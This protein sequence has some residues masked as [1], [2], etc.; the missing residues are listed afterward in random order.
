[1]KKNYYS[2]LLLLGCYLTG[3]AQ[4]TTISSFNTLI[5]SNYNLGLVNPLW[6]QGCVMTYD[7]GLVNTNGAAFTL[8]FTNP[9]GTGF[10][11]YP[12]GTVGNFKANSTYYT[13]NTS[14]C[15]LPVKIQNLGNNL[16]LKWKVSQENANDAD[17]K[18]WATINV[19]FDLSSTASSEPNPDA[20]DF[21]LVIQLKSYEQDTFTNL[22][23]TETNNYT[24]WYFARNTD[25]SLKT[26]DLYLN[27]IMYQFA[28][29]YKFFNYPQ[30]N[31]DGT[32]NAN[33]DKNDKVH[34]KFIPLNNNV[35][36]PNL[37]HSLKY[38]IDKSKEYKSFLPLTASESVLFDQKVAD[39]NLWIKAVSAGYEVYTG[40][41]TIKNDY[42]NTVLD[43]TAPAA[44]LNLTVTTVTN[45][46][47][48]DWSDT[49][50][51][52]FDYYKIYRAINGG[53]FSLLADNVRQSNFTDATVVA[54]KKYTYYVVAVDRSFNVSQGSSKK[55]T[56]LSTN[57]VTSESLPLAVKVYPNPTKGLITILGLE[58]ENITVEIYNM[59]GAQVL[60]IDNC[61]QPSIDISALQDGMY[62][63]H[64]V[65]QNQISTFKIVKN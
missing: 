41:F 25:N 27:G 63:L 15:G 50:V 35:P 52:D 48:L 31:A 36:I 39:P 55:T 16:R 49:T 24:Y 20:R 14:V 59:L 18:W 57:R 17:D 45:K 7:S 23:S 34:V 58:D 22:L 61:S 65:T 64:L 2:I 32:L 8:N 26:V 9:G 44:P 42:F 53:S 12:S 11:G 3:F 19:I 1:M 60:R 62:M 51:S 5:K 54:G 40:S 33:F 4:I 56:S 21:D 10:K 29:R 37:D 28:V 46:L 43:Q 13:G 6:N 38:F 47:F 30:Y